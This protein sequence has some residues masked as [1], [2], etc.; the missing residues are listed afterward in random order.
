MPSP[1]GSGLG[2]S[3]GSGGGLGGLDMFGN[4]G[5]FIF[6]FKFGYV[7]IALHQRQTT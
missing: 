5:M 2:S 1:F 7:S 4:A 6:Y 3:G